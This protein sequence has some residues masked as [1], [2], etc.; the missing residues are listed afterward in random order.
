MKYDLKQITEFLSE[1]GVKNSKGKPLSL[2]LVRKALKPYENLCHEETRLDTKKRKQAVKTYS[3]MT[4][5]K[6]FLSQ[7]IHDDLTD[8]LQEG[9]IG[10]RNVV[11]KVEGYQVTIEDQ[12][13][14]ISRLEDRIEYL[15]RRLNDSDVEDGY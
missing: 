15:E 3:E 7:T 6:V 5:I 12:K 10:I 11:K 14:Q 1:C 2:D 13:S 8:R 9:L 4:L